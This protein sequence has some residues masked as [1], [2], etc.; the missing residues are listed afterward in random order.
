MICFVPVF[1]KQ[2]Y[3]PTLHQDRSDQTTKNQLIKQIDEQ[4]Q[5]YG[6]TFYCL[7]FLIHISYQK[8]Q[9]PS[10]LRGILYFV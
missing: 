6:P 9:S 7:P 3:P 4:I 1:T 10:I 5:S 8:H 2:K